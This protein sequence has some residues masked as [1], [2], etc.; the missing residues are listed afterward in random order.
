ME[1][2]MNEPVIW[3]ILIV[4]VMTLILSLFSLLRSEGNPQGTN[5]NVRDELRA[6]RDESRV[7]GRELRE[8][9]T[10]SLEM[11]ASAQQH[12]LDHLERQFT[13]VNRSNS[14][15]RIQIHETFNHFASQLQEANQ[16]NLAD[17][18]GNVQEKLEGLTLQFRELNESNTSSLMQVQ[19]L[20][21]ARVREL[22]E[23]NDKKLE[24][25]RKTVDEKLHESLERR[26]GESFQLVSERLEAVHKGLG[27]MQTLATGV[28]DLKRV[29]SNV[30]VR[31]TW[32]EAQLGN[33]LDEVLTQDQYKK[34]FEVKKHTNERV[35]F[36]IKLPGQKND[37]ESHI[38][39]PID[40]KFPQEDYLRLQEASE[41]ADVTGIKAATDSLMNA[42]KLSAKDISEKYVDPPVTTDFCIMFLPT[43]GLYAEVLR[44]PTVAEEIRQRHRVLIAGPMTIVAI[45][46]SIR[47]GFDTLAIEQHASEAWRVLGAVKT[48][49]KKFGET[50]DRVKRQLTTASNTIDLTGQRSRVIQRKLQ[51]VGELP[52]HESKLLLGLPDIASIDDQ[53]YLDEIDIAHVPVA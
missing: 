42:V 5:N 39:L 10:R 20:L 31:G 37:P 7:T 14:E 28:G 17:I 16:K 19:R 44:H 9:L 22:Q 51:S 6:G 49:F 40:S 35:D 2:I 4:S 33:I 41:Q 1:Y 29:L 53:D 21:D 46:W 47:K 50:L 23:N 25:I 13:E 3:I 48:E 12:K 27:E 15:A 34:N 30:K 8:E 38:W 24:E 26:L 52:L 11:A 36:A 32:A 43:E 45:L 18:K